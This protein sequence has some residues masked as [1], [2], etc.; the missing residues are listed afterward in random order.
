[1]ERWINRR[2]TKKEE[3]R[4]M[5]LV[6][7]YFLISNLPAELYN[8]YFL[9]KVGKSIGTM[10]KV[11]EHTSIYSRGKFAHICME[12]DLS[13]KLVPFSSALGKEFRLEYEC[14][15]L[16][17]FNCEPPEGE[18]A[19]VVQGQPASVNTGNHVRKDLIATENPAV[20]EVAV[21]TV[22]KSHKYQSGEKISYLTVVNEESLY[23]P[24]MVIKKS[25]RKNRQESGSNYGD[26]KKKEVLIIGLMLFKMIKK[27]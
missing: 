13:K 9:W 7:G 2:W 27:L 18:N 25:Q 14:L 3:V 4:M 5:D 26:I 8:R 22:K 23:G 6:G 19:A 10:H 17:C 11:D 15:H 12:I 24:S 1:M 20:M 21:G 16:I